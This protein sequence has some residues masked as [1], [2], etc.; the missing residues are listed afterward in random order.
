MEITGADEIVLFERT[1]FLKVTSVQSELGEENP[2]EDRFEKLS[3]IIK[4]FKASISCVSPSI[5]FSFQ[6]KFTPTTIFSPE[7]PLL[8]PS[9]HFLLNHYRTSLLTRPRSRTYTN[10]STSSHQFLELYIKT[11]RF[12]LIITLLTNNTYALV[13]LPPGEVEMHCARL[14]L[15]DAREQFSKLDGWDDKRASR[16]PPWSG[17]V[18]VRAT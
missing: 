14:N 17:G 18:S 2:H 10:E 6:D 4:T 5:I 1:T 7:R 9:R 11:P 15:F 3:S 13:V 16:S 8:F 12:N